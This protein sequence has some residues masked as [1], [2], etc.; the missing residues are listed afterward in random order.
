MGQ[1]QWTRWRGGHNAVKAES[2][3]L[4]GVRM[5]VRLLPTGKWEAKIAGG[6]IT[7]LG[8]YDTVEEAQRRCLNEARLNINGSFHDLNQHEALV[9]LGKGRKGKGVRA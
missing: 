8:E 1:L 3:D 7:T 5:T 4:G 6:G 9:R 2:L